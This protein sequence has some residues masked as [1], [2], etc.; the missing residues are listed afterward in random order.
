MTSVSDLKI[1]DFADLCKV[2]FLILV[3]YSF[4]LIEIAA[5]SI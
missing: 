1:G 3:S 4:S 2:D 5:L